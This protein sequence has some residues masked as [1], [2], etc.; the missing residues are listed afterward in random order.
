MTAIRIGLADDQ[1]LFRAGIRMIIESQDDFEVVWEASDGAEAIQRQTDEPVDLI[2]MDLE[3]PRVS[4][5][6]ATSR[7][8]TSAPS[9]ALDEA[10]S[11][12]TPAAAS[13]PARIVVLTTFELNDKAFQAIQAGASGFLLKNADPEFL[14]AAIRTVHA[15][16]AV[17]APSMMNGLV[18]RFAR[19]TPRIDTDALGELTVRERDIFAL[20]ASGLSNNEIAAQRQLSDATVKS[21]VSRI[22][23]KLHLRDRVQLVIFAYENGLVSQE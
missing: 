17:V 16:S 18:E 2:L 9:P 11:P 14:L 8:L 19:R 13:P 20:L 21:H 22:L 6:E 7:I 10:P 12:G 1:P 15:G 23:Q 4:G 3:M 5:V